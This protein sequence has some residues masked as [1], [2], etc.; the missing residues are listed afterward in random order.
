[1]RPIAIS[2][3]PNT[4][5][6]DVEL[7]RQVL[8]QPTSWENQQLVFDVEHKLAQE[9]GHDAHA[10]ATSSGRQ[11]LY[12]LL[13]V[14][15]IGPG[16]EVIIQAFTCIAVPAP[17]LWTGATPIYADINPDT[18]S[19]DPT[20]VARKITPRTKAIILQH[21]FGI[22]G[23]VAEIQALA[24]QHGL[25]L[26]ED[27]AHALGVFVHGQPL[28]VAG[29]AAIVSFGRDK[30]ISSVFGGAIVSRQSVIIDRA[31]TLDELLPLP[32]PAWV[33]QQLRHP[34]AFSKIVPAYFKG[35]GKYSLVLQQTF[36]RLSKAVASNEKSGGKPDHLDY[37]FSPALATLVLHQL[38]KLGRYMR[39]R[40]EI[41]QRYA[42]ALGG[43][44]G[45]L[46]RFPVERENAP[47]LLKLA[48]QK[49][50]LLGD[51][52]S[53]P[54]APADADMK[55]HRYTPGSCPVAE[56]VGRRI[57]NLPTYPLLTDDQVQHII[58]F[59]KTA[60]S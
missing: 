52:Y 26:I 60:P 34:I 40:E 24:R 49:E 44:T 4:E 13:K 39:R 14:F 28:G 53:T 8:R 42:H 43:H 35:F 27:C 1:M 30:G 59:M 56:R 33:A 48:R 54:L 41:T 21:T 12:D 37:R 22:P 46:L 47:Q 9:F 57:I 18:Y 29:D 7:A 19:V 3:S 5:P 51:W 38:D 58:H 32:P 31:R 11:A 6:D 50:I 17:I 23:P 10:Y 45:A 2:L 15:G 25:R 16:D 36:G 20:D 55:A